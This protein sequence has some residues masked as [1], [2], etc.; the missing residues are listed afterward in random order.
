[1]RE[2]DP[3]E[4]QSHDAC[5]REGGR[6]G[7]RR[8]G[9]EGREGGGIS[10]DPWGLKSGGRGGG[11]LVG[12]FSTSSLPPPL[13][14][15]F[16]SPSPFPSLPPPSLPPS[17]LPSL[18]RQRHRLREG[19]RSVREEEEEANL[20]LGRVFEVRMLANIAASQGH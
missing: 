13:P 2:N 19:I 16:L 17:S 4:K 1:M 5:G 8:G 14:P 15:P 6:G 18:T 20:V 7:G 12:P 11:G 10:A 9:R 3:A